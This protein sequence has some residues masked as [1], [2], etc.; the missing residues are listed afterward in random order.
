ME[1][2]RQIGE[3]LNEN[4]DDIKKAVEKQLEI[5]RKQM[6]ESREE[7]IRIELEKFAYA[8]TV[9]TPAPSEKKEKRNSLK[10]IIFGDNSSASYRK[11]DKDNISRED[12]LSIKRSSSDYNMESK[13]KDVITPAKLSKSTTDIVSPSGLLNVVNA[14]KNSYSS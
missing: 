14:F 5:D 2:S 3:G 12:S 11:K 1:S 4:L 7:K 8:L 13:S 6:Q 10:G 9:E